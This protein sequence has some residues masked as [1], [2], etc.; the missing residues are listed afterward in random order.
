MLNESDY[1][2]ELEKCLFSNKY[3]FVS[4]YN[5]NDYLFKYDFID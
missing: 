5:Y 1:F 4:K 2:L 3:K